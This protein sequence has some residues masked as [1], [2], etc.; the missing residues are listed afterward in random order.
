MLIV[1]GE[2]RL[3]LAG[4]HKQNSIGSSPAGRAINV[5][6]ERSLGSAR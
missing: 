3:S 4:E 1:V 6:K 5:L 2:T